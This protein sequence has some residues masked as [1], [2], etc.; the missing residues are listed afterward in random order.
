MYTK[1]QVLAML[2]EMEQSELVALIEDTMLK[3]VPQRTIDAFM[4]NM[5]TSDAQCAKN[6]KAFS[7][8]CKNL[9]GNGIYELFEQDRNCIREDVYRYAR[10][11]LGV[12]LEDEIEPTRASIYAIGKKFNVQSMIEY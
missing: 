10:D 8:K 2:S 4:H 9:E 3:H 6:V 11:V 1:E 12:K 5:E 7:A